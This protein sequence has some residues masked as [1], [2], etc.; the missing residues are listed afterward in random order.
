LG[1]GRDG[2]FGYMERM[3][4][5]DTLTFEH[6]RVG[7]VYKGQK[8]ENRNESSS[9]VDPEYEAISGELIESD[10]IEFKPAYPYYKN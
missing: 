5:R 1:G 8:L 6:D 7:S 4:R 3:R 9:F 10:E 2:G